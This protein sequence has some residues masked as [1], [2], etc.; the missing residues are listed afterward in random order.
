MEKYMSLKLATKILES[1][2]V[3]R[4]KQRL[5]AVIT[6]RKG[7]VLS[8]GQN[9]YSKTHPMQ[10]LAA[11]R[12]GRESVCFMHSEIDAIRR[13]GRDAH[14][15]HN[16]YVAR[17]DKQGQTVLAKPCEICQSMIDIMNLNVE[18]TI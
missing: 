6:D 14:K 13:L 7:N 8:I 3:Q 9:S 4:G 10:A 12:V 5:C 17:L 15:A 16:I 18:Y 11:K 2:P 1:V